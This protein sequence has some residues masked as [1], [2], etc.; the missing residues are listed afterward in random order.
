M[1]YLPLLISSLYIYIAVKKTQLQP[2]DQLPPDNV[3]KNVTINLM[4][5]EIIFLL[6]WLFDPVTCDCSVSFV[7]VFLFYIAQDAYYYCVHKYIFHKFLHQ[8]HSI[9]H[10]YILSFATWYCHPLEHIF[11][12]LG[13]IIIP[14]WIFNNPPW[15]LAI[16]IIQQVYTSIAGYNRK[17]HNGIHNEY[18]TKRFGSI[19]LLDYL[20]DT[21]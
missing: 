18:L 11:L 13:S 20:N 16:I 17:S 2:G 19:Y 8:W 9:H 4:M 21:F 12:N 10:E 15:I 7:K 6:G 3:L 1:Y 14:F 5:T